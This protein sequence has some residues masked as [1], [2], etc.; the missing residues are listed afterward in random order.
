MMSVAAMTFSANYYK[1]LWDL[2]SSDDLHHEF[3]WHRLKVLAHND[4]VVVCFT[5]NETKTEVL[6]ITETNKGLLLS[7]WRQQ[8][9]ID[10]SVKSNL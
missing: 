8:R 5:D 4:V 2:S 1:Y 10:K 9:Y 6:E 3:L 7:T